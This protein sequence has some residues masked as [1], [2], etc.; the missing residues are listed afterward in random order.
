MENVTETALQKKKRGEGLSAPLSVPAGAHAPFPLP[1]L[2]PAFI[3]QTTRGG[4]RESDSTFPLLSSLRIFLSSFV[5]G[6][7]SSFSCCD[8]GLSDV[9]KCGKWRRRRRRR[10]EEK[11]E[12]KRKLTCEK[13]SRS[14]SFPLLLRRP[15]FGP[16]LF[17]HRFRNGF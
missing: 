17:R 10:Q 3:A 13:G 7:L 5:P 16:L 15:R 8:R 12:R 14:L 11:E 6:C 9:G 1:L 2:G 4:E